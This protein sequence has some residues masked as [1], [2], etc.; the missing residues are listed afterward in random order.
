MEKAKTDEVA[1]VLQGMHEFIK[2][3]QMMDMDYHGIIDALVQDY[4]CRE[5]AM[6]SV[7]KKAQ[8]DDLDRMVWNEDN[9]EE[10]KEHS[11]NLIIDK[12][13]RVSLLSDQ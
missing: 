13:N 9:D 11:Q 7:R 8:H 3:S 5:L 1:P 12:I 6:K 2:K 4:G 10:H